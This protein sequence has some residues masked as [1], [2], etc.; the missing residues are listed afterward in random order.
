MCSIV[1]YSHLLTHIHSKVKCGISL[2]T[3]IH[4]QGC[5]GYVYTNILSLDVWI[6]YTLC[7]LKTYTGTLID[8]FRHKSNSLT[9]LTSLYGLI[10]LTLHRQAYN[11]RIY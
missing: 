11:E 2:Y 8:N 9:L 4:R 10:Y 7:V 6:M 1:V 5:L 3:Y